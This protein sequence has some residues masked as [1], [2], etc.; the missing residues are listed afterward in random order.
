MLKIILATVWT[1]KPNCTPELGLTFTQLRIAKSCESKWNIRAISYNTAGFVWQNELPQK[2]F[3]HQFCRRRHSEND[4]HLISKKS[5]ALESE[6]PSTES[7]IA[8]RRSDVL[9][10][11]FILSATQIRT[12]SDATWLTP[13]IRRNTFQRMV[14]TSPRLSRWCLSP[15]GHQK[16]MSFTR[17]S[18]QFLIS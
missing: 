10:N 2:P 7:E 17:F 14:S 11:P 15:N 6:E 1:S 8:K 18:Q 12:V 13:S 5:L 9:N 16:F 3:C 4:N